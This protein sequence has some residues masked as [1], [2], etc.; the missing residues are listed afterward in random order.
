MHLERQPVGA[1]DKQRRNLV[2]VEEE[3]FIRAADRAGAAGA[4]ILSTFP[5]GRAAPALLAPAAPAAP[6]AQLD[7]GGYPLGNLDI[8][9]YNGSR[10]WGSILLS[11]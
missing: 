7:T 3:P 1:G 10:I 2:T 5:L 4:R 8:L 11:V 6:A 9:N